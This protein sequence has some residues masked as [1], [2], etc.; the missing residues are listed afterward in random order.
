M[1]QY[2]TLLVQV[3][4]G[5]DAQRTQHP[6][7]H[8]ANATNLPVRILQYYYL[9]QSKNSYCNLKIIPCVEIGEAR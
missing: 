9:E 7:R 8:F 1:K 3:A 5:G 2:T 4:T 6:L